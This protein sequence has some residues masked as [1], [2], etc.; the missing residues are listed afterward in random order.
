MSSAWKQFVNCL[1]APLTNHANQCVNQFIGSL[2]II[3]MVKVLMVTL[4]LLTLCTKRTLDN[5]QCLNAT[6][7]CVWLVHKN[8]ETQFGGSS[9]P[10]FD[11]NSVEQNMTYVTL[12]TTSHCTTIAMNYV[13]A[14]VCVC[15]WLIGQFIV[16]NITSIM[17]LQQ[18]PAF[19]TDLI[20]ANEHKCIN[21]GVLIINAISLD[22]SQCNHQWV[23]V[24]NQII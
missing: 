23:V 19:R 12:T 8:D 16:I 24:S 7:K 14:Y 5:G 6:D 3:K 20:S 4:L 9:C 22:C 2:I 17:T 11:I 1:V 15:V 21:H 10:N 18:S 13:S